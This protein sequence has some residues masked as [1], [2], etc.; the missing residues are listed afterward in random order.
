MAHRYPLIVAN[1]KM[2]PSLADAMVLSESYQEGLEDLRHIEVAIAAPFVWLYPIKEVLI[3]K[4]LAH[5]SL[6]AQNLA[7]E[8][9]GAFTGEVSAP[10]LKTLCQYVLIGHSE[11]RQLGDD[12]EVVNKKIHLALKWGLAPI[13]F[14]SQ[15]NRR[16]DIKNTLDLLSRL[17]NGV[18]KKDYEEI[19]LVYEPVWAISTNS[20][21]GGAS[22]VEIEPVIEAMRTK[23]GDQPRILYGGSV[24]EKN[25][26]E[27]LSLSELDG[28]VVGSASQKQ[29]LFIEIC[30]LA[31]GRN[32]AQ[33]IIR[34]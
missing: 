20:Q 14:V 26:A 15:E 24:N 7:S 27:F 1:W 18:A 10:M 9:E 34:Y 28:L 29:K 3:R 31:S 8:E 17:L 4:K 25:T 16:I 19:N 30:Q 6:A 2:Y 21:S 23:V 5:L 22:G 11:R 32:E 13:I 33:D 12:P